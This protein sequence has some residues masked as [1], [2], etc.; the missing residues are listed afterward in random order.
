MVNMVGTYVENAPHSCSYYLGHKF[1]FYN[2]V[3]IW[4]SLWQ[5]GVFCYFVHFPTFWYVLAIKIWQP[6]SKFVW[7]NEQERLPIM[8]IQESIR[9]RVNFSYCKI[10]KHLLRA[11]YI[12]KPK[13]TLLGK[14]WRTLKLKMLV[15]FWPLGIYYVHLEYIFYGRSEI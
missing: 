3:G 12:F 4:Y 15:Y 11:W 9:S 13:I 5:F 14:F 1:I 7:R 10:M 6:W 8:L 2:Y